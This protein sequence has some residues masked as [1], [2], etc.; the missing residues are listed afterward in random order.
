MKLAESCIFGLG[1]RR[2]VCVN[3][4]FLAFLDHEWASGFHVTGHAEMLYLVQ[5]SWWQP[6]QPDTV[7]GRVEDG[8]QRGDKPRL[9]GV[10]ADDLEDGLLDPMPV[11]F[12]DLGDTAESNLPFPRR[13]VHVVGDQEVHV[14]SPSTAGTGPDRR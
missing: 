6:V 5:G 3:S 13:G 7:L 8:L 12:A 2:V 14:S 10:G 11:G 4:E 9:V 1:T